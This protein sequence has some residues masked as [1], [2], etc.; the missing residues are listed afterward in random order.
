MA[1]LFSNGSLFKFKMVWNAII[2]IFL[3]VKEGWWHFNVV[4]KGFPKTGGCG[5]RRD[6]SEWVFIE[7]C[8]AVSR[9]C[10]NR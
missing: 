1:T 10:G 6:A 2:F 4:P 3:Q 7:A 9:S 5:C 8:F